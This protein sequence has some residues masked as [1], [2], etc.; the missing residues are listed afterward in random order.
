MRINS[1]LGSSPPLNIIVLP[2]LFEGSVRAVVELAS[3]SPF[4][5]DPSDLPRPAHRRASASSSTPSKPTPSPRTCSKQSQSQAEEL[6]SQQEELRESNED[7]G[8]QARLLAEQNSEAEQKNQ[9]VEQSKR[10]VEE[11]AG[12]LAISSKYKSEFI[13]NMSHEL[14]TPLNSLLIL[15]EQLEDNPEH[16]HDRYPGRVR[17]CHPGFR[18]GPAGPSQQHPRAGQGRVW[19]RYRR[20]DRAVGRTDLRAALVREFEHVARGKGIDYSD[21]SGTRQHPSGSSP[22]P[23]ASARS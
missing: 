6:R 15:A 21:R 20:A 8:R 3:F 13:A 9:E 23:N 1:G 5:A 4:S 18:Q 14:R 19:H 22:T 12:Q 7:L 10:L 16:N 11:K 17:Q 2:V